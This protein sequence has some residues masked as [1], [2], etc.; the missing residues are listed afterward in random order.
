[1]LALPHLDGIPIP[2]I[3]HRENGNKLKFANNPEMPNHGARMK[4][5]PNEF[6]N[7][8]VPRASDSDMYRVCVRTSG[9]TWNSSTL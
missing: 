1:M 8:A 7:L 2:E 6:K 5:S 3:D 9:D 4:A